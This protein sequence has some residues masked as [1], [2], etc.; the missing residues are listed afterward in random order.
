M[1]SVNKALAII[2]SHTT[3]RLLEISS[4]KNVNGHVLGED[5]FS[6]INL[7][8]FRQSAM[9]GYAVSGSKSLSFKVIGEVQAG[10]NINITLKEG[11][12]V[13]VF[14]GA[15]VPKGTTRVLMQEHVEE[16]NGV[17]TYLKDSFGK[18][19]VKETGEQI[20]KGSVA[21]SKGTL[22]NASAVAFLSGLGIKDVSVFKMPKVSILVSGNELQAPGE[23]LENGK[24]YDSNSIMLKLLLQKIGVQNV[25]VVFVGDS[26]HE[27]TTTVARLLEDSHFIIAS[28]GI[29]VGEYDLIRHAFEANSV[30]EKFYKI[31]QRP[32][33]PIY[34]G[35]KD[36][37][38][39]FGLPG[40]PA[41]CFI[42]FQVYVLP[43]LRRFIGIENTNGFK[44]A[45]L[46]ESI[47]NPTGK[48]LFL[49]A[50]VT[51]NT[52]EIFKNQSSAMLQSLID[53]NALAYIPE[54]TAVCDKGK[55]ILYLDI[56]Q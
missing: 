17:I 29:S 3:A 32:G 43:A 22:L 7:P 9:D 27:I 13:R 33:K 52:I 20:K 50:K 42:N 19:N 40:N 55:E 11:E 4:L 18:N 36:E 25:E 46:L 34:F 8:P 6:E 24:I 38:S 28:G 16:V 48:S 14:T 1:I 31:N 51:G 45:T 49:R 39:V 26:K 44:K 35:K 5:V 15:P 41:A 47:S 30:E 10:S 54:D 56:L 21:L 37:V 12:A 2:K 23:A 53:A